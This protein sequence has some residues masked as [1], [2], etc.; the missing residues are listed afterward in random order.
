MKRTSKS[1][2]A[3]SVSPVLK[4][5]KDDMAVLLSDGPYTGIIVDVVEYHDRVTLTSGKV[6][7]HETA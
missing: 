3:L 5:R 4:C 6:Y 1:A 2:T 7:G